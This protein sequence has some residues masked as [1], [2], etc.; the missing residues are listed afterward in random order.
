MLANTDS[1]CLLWGALFIVWLLGVCYGVHWLLPGCWMFVMGCIGY[2]LAAGYL[3][4][5]ALVIVWLLSVS[6]NVANSVMTA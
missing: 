3:L 2:C 1:G 4:W 6:S 5:G